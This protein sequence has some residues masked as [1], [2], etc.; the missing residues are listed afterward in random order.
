MRTNLPDFRKKHFFLGITF[1]SVVALAAF[2][3]TSHF[4]ARADNPTQL[5][6]CLSTNP[7]L[8][9]GL[10]AG[11]DPISPCPTG[12]P[13]VS[14]ISE[15]KRHQSTGTGIQYIT[16]EETWIDI[17]NASISA[18][19]VGG[20]W[21]ATYTGVLGMLGGD[22]TAQVRLQVRPEGG[23]PTNYAT[24]QMYHSSSP[25]TTENTTQP[26][27][28][29]TLMTLPSGEVSV[30]PQIHSNNDQF[31]LLTGSVLIIEH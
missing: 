5:T 7:G 11:A 4:V 31:Y 20:Q 24:M 3:F 15:I 27:T 1:L 25:T 16:P 26:F 18:N 28:L 29:Q 6:G 2:F 17:P 10:K 22:G 9:Y 23:S 8:L 21:K 12:D 19:V 13:E 30:V 14:M